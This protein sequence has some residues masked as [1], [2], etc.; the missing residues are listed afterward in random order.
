MA[1]LLPWVPFRLALVIASLTCLA[2]CSYLA[3]LGWCAPLRTAKDWCSL[4]LHTL[5]C[6][7]IIAATSFLA[8]RVSIVK[9][10]HHRSRL[11]HSI[12]LEQ[13]A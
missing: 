12:L 9:F 10:T 2:V 11:G 6:L 1:V 4:L 13:A 5:H 7:I 3:A 8:F